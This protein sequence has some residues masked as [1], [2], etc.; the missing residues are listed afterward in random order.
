MCI[1]DS[2]G[3]LSP[4]VGAAAEAPQEGGLRRQHGARRDHRRGG[5][6]ADDRG[7]G[8]RLFYPT[9]ASRGRARVGLGGARVL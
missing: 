6:D 8:T 1:R 9:Y 4:P 3:D 7:G 5:V 2:A